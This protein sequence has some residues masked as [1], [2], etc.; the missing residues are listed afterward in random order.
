MENW[1]LYVCAFYLIEVYFVFVD[2]YF[3]LVL[4]FTHA[5]L[6]HSLFLF[7]LPNLI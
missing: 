1:C 6:P 7:I 2:F 3:F 5:K 4:V